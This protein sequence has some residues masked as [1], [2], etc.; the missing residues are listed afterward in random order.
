[1]CRFKLESNYSRIEMEVHQTLITQHTHLLE[2][3]YSR[4][5]MNFDAIIWTG[6][7]RLESNYSRIEMLDM[8]HLPL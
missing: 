1:M 4:I 2:S 6:D 5:E 8:Q 7:S 3:N